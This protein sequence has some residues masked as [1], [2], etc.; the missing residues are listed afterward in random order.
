MVVVPAQ[1][2]LGVSGPISRNPTRRLARAL[3]PMKADASPLAVVMDDFD[4]LLSGSTLCW[5]FRIC[6]KSTVQ[7]NYK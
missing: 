3:D 7:I 4:T 5:A 6:S 2:T 1:D